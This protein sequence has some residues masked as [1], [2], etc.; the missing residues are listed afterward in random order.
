MIS[1]FMSEKIPILFSERDPQQ[2]SDTFIMNFV[3][4][5][6]FSDFNSFLSQTLNLKNDFLLS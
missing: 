6:A 5:S 3:F 2:R 4:N 1:L